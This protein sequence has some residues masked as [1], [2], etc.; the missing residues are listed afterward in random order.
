MRRRG[1]ART[2]DA[3]HRPGPGQRPGKRK[4]FPTRGALTVAPLCRHTPPAREGAACSL[5]FAGLGEQTHLVLPLPKNPS[6]GFSKGTRPLA[7]LDL[8]IP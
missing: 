7:V 6:L 1:R 5:P 3:G 8:A 2:L 4:G